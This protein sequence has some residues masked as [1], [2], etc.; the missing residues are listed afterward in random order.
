MT[1]K[2]PTQWDRQK[3]LANHRA[4]TRDGREVFSLAAAI[5][6]G[7]TV[8]VGKVATRNQPYPDGQIVRIEA[9]YW[10]DGGLGL[11][12]GDDLMSHPRD[13]ED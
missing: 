8:L 13:T 4:M 7:K 9:H 6:D 1:P 11:H 5:L 3:A 10:S 2:S 12:G